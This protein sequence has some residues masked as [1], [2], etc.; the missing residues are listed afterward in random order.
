MTSKRQECMKKG[1]LQAYGRVQRLA[2]RPCQC[3]SL[4]N[5]F[6]PRRLITGCLLWVM[7]R[8][9]DN[10]ADHFRFPPTN[11]HFQLQP[12]SSQTGIC[13]LMCRQTMEL[14]D[15]QALV[16]IE[17]SRSAIAAIRLSGSKHFGK[18]LSTPSSPAI[19][20]AHHATPCSQALGRML[21]HPLSELRRAH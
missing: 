5:T 20:F 9:F 17:R 13:A 11:G 2:R 10:G 3:G 18:L 19:L 15:R 7:N 6:R 12:E 4:Q 8:H 1:R 14:L 21:F 16:A